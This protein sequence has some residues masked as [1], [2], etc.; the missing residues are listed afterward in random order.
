M[1]MDTKG[2][3]KGANITNTLPQSKEHLLTLKQHLPLFSIAQD[4]DFKET[5]LV[6]K[7]YACFSVPFVLLIMLSTHGYGH[8]RPHQGR[9]Y[10]RT[11][12]NRSTIKE[13]AKGSQHG[14]QHDK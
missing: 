14:T 8:Q 7:N 5:S 10:H 3:I 11:D 4:D 2:P 9:Q 12:N 6:L 1:D 13:Q